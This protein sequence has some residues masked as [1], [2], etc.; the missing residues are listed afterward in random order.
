VDIFHEGAADFDFLA[1]KIVMKIESPQR[2]AFRV[3]PSR[4]CT[5]GFFP[6]RH[7]GRFSFIDIT[8]PSGIVRTWNFIS[9]L[10]V[11][12]ARASSSYV[13]RRLLDN[14]DW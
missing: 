5:R 8:M 3:N 10:F 14:F 13:H 6:I 7:L 12:H 4:P 1:E 2:D 9:F 11:S